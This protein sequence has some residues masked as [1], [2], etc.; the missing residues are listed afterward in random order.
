[1]G[2]GQ[3]CAAATKDSEH[4]PTNARRTLGLR[5]LAE[6]QM[7]L[8]L[9]IVSYTSSV[10]RESVSSMCRLCVVKHGRSIACGKLLI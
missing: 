8:I 2:V 5:V 6:G 3:R 10:Y 7:N 9:R 4:I 1:M